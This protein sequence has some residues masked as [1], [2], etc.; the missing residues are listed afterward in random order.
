MFFSSAAQ[1]NERTTSGV[2]ILPSFLKCVKSVWT[3]GPFSYAPEF[4]M[5]LAFTIP[6]SQTPGPLWDKKPN[7]LSWAAEKGSRKSGERADSRSLRT[8]WE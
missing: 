1:G 8:S 7:S 2:T 6:N 3:E 5:H 4:P